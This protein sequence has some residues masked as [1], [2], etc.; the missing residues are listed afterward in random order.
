MVLRPAYPGSIGYGQDYVEALTSPAFSVLEVDASLAAFDS[1]DKGLGYSAP[2][3]RRFY[4]GLSH[5]GYIGAWIAG[6]YKDAVKA[7]VLV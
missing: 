6:R 7:M 1:L 5:G 3:D 4:Y 2:L